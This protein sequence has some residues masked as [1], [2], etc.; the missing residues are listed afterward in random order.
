M[1]QAVLLFIGF[2]GLAAAY[3]GLLVSAF[4]VARSVPPDPSYP[5]AGLGS[6]L[7]ISQSGDQLILH[8]PPS[9]GARFFGTI[10]SMIIPV[11]AVIAA[12]YVVAKD[13]LNA[14]DLGRLAVALFLSVAAIVACPW[15]WLLF[16]ES[17]EIDGE[18]FT[19]KFA[20]TSVLDHIWRRSRYEWSHVTNPRVQSHVRHVPLHYRVLFNYSVP[21]FLG[22]TLQ[23]GRHL[24]IAEAQAFVELIRSKLPPE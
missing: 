4:R 11:C 7:S 22:A 9:T 13:G 23:V 12:T 14:A 5:L 18:G 19:Y 6:R 8:V 10:L 3:V 20:S 15:R 1:L 16:G 17:F 2:A 24:S 21:P